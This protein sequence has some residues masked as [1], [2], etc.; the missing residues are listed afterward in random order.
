MSKRVRGSPW[1]GSCIS[2]AP[3]E[4]EELLELCESYSIRLG[5][6]R[7]VATFSGPRVVR[8]IVPTVIFWRNWD[9]YYWTFRRLGVIVNKADLAAMLWTRLA[10]NAKPILDLPDRTQL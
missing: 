4:T 1:I 5:E 6:P 3:F 8:T 2:R 9:R 10:P 7:I